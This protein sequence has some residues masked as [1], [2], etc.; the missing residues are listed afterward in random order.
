MAFVAMYELKAL[1]I[2]LYAHMLYYEI[3]E[4]EK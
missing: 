2:I 4:V 1:R 3:K